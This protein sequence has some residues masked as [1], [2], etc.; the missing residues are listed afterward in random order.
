[1]SK[2]PGLRVL[3]RALNMG[4]VGGYV[5]F[6]RK[7]LSTPSWL[8]VPFALLGSLDSLNH[9]KS[10]GRKIQKQ[11]TVQ[12]CPHSLMRWTPPM[13]WRC[14]TPNL[15]FYQQVNG[16]VHLIRKFRR[17]TYLIKPQDPL[18]LSFYLIFSP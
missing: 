13:K 16:D 11:N 15:V 17:S 3:Y 12:D 14:N 2:N 4:A 1:M 5:F 9:E 8:R 18:A 6:R 10:R 7:I